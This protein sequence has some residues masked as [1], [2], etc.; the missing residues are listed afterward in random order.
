MATNGDLTLTEL[1]AETLFYHGSVV[2]SLRSKCF[3]L[4]G[5]ML[6]G[7]SPRSAD[8]DARIFCGWSVLTLGG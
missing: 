7:N 2:H 8:C 3:P 1:Q 5:A 6:A 4:E